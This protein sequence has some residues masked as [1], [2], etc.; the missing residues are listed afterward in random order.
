[1]QKIWLTRDRDALLN[2]AL[3]LFDDVL[4]KYMVSHFYFIDLHDFEG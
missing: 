3:P 1:L 4:S 2:Y